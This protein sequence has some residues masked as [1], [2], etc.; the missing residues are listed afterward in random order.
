M[1]KIQLGKPGQGRV[2]LQ[3]YHDRVDLDVHATP[4]TP[5]ETSTFYSITAAVVS[6]TTV[7]LQ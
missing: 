2:K 5:Q 3:R 6:S 1:I 7:V 4:N